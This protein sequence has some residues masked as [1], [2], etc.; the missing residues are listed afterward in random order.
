MFAQMMIAHLEQGVDMAVV[1]KA[2]ATRQELRDLAAAVDSTQRE[3]LT[4]LKS[5]LQTWGKPTTTDH[6]P[7]AH[8]HHGGLPLIDAK[9]LNDLK[10]LSGAEFDTT[11]LNL[12]TGHQGGAV[13]MARTEIADGSNPETKAYAD[14]VVQSRQAQVSQMLG[15]VG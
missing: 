3:E 7:N 14:R 6:N 5:W 1:A 10:D 11:Y 4:T 2:K 15:L 9:V 12:M 8:A 13:E